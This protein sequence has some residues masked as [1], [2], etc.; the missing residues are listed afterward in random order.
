[1]LAHGRSQYPCHTYSS[2]GRVAAI[3]YST[4]G[5]WTLEG[6][7]LFPSHIDFFLIILTFLYY[8][9]IWLLLI[10]TVSWILLSI[11]K[12]MGF[13]GSSNVLICEFSINVF[14]FYQTDSVSICLFCQ[15]IYIWRKITA[16]ISLSIYIYHV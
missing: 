11:L 7:Y 13:P 10:L 3:Y 1:M 2:L 4:V 9:F 14:K 5:I 12:Q 16:S 15:Q 8:Y 6:E